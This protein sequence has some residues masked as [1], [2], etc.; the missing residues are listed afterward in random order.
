MFKV[1]KAPTFIA[2]LAALSIFGFTSVQAAELKIGYIDIKTALENTA[3]YQS[4]MTTLKALRDKKLTQLKALKDKI[5]RAEKDI[6]R[7][8]LAMSQEHL[9]QKQRDLKE[10]GKNFQRAQQDAQ[11][12]LAAK[13][14][15][16]DIASMAKF[17]KVITAYG[18]SHHYDMII[19]RPVFLYVDAKHDLTGDITKLLDK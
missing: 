18:K 2:A 7:Q 5:D 12:A 3:E 9:A 13:K 1:L 10:M 11:E 8:S 17:Q 16:M 14:N 4:G 15:T 6:M 19:P